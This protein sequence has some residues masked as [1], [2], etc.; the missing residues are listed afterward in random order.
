MVSD[1]FGSGFTWNTAASFTNTGTL[2]I[3]K[4]DFNAHTL[5]NFS[6]TTLSGGTYN[7]WDGTLRFD[8]A[9]IET[10]AAGTALAIR[11]GATVLDQDGHDALLNFSRNQGTFSIGE[12]MN[13][14][15]KPGFEN[16]GTLTVGKIETFPLLFG[17]PESPI[18]R[19]AVLNLTGNVTNSGHLLAYS[20]LPADPDPSTTYGKGIINLNHA[21]LDQ[22]GGGTLQAAEGGLI[23]LNAATVLG[24]GQ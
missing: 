16:S 11:N 20:P 7:I 8:N 15:L 2:Y 18:T 5:T 1:Y 9:A 4:V 22:T 23:N 6:G 3:R 19:D 12:A 24:G 14:T 10:L 21:T 17:V 13:F